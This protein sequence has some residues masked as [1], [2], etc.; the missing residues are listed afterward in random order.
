MRGFSDSEKLEQLYELYEQKMYA[1]AFSIL[2][3]EWQAEDAVQDA[4]VRLLKNL[5]KIRDLESL[6]TRSYVLRTIRSAAIDQYRKNQITSNATV[7]IKD[8]DFADE[9]DDIM[10]LVSRLAGDSV[11]ERIL[12][13]LPDSY[14][15]VILFRCVHQLSVKETASVLEISESLVRKRQQRALKKLRLIIGDDMYPTYKDVINYPIYFDA[16]VCSDSSDNH[17][18]FTSLEKGQTITCHL[19][20]IVDEDLLDQLCLNTSFD[21]QIGQ[22][23]TLYK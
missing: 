2:R 11:L 15:D 12:G 21:G 20:Y 5:W 10:K 6:K 18:F 4:F 9:R 1:V 16:S 22:F 7:P 3:N 19:G 17:Y 23:V 8:M 13:K 14:R